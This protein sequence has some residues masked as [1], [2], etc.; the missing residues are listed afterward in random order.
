MF[1]WLLYP[2]HKTSEALSF[3]RVF[4]Y[5][6][7]R[8][9]FA[10]IT[11][12]LLAYYLGPKAIRFLKKIKFG[13]AISE[14]GP[15]SHQ[16][17]AGTPTMGG[18][19]II[20]SMS[21]SA[22]LWGNLSNLY[23]L[24]LLLGTLFLSAVGFLDDYQKSILKITGGMKAKVKFIFQ[25]FIALGVALII[26]YF[27]TTPEDNLKMATDLYLPFIKDPIFNMGIWAVPFWVIVITGS[28]NAVNLTDGLDG[29]A[30]GLSVIVLVTLGV[31]S[32]I[33]GLYKI[34]GYLLLP[35]FPE[36]NE[37]SVFLAALIGASI[38]FLWY[39][40]YPAEVFMGD[41]G[42]LAIGG[43]VGITAILIKREILLL[44]IGGIFVV[45]VISVILQVFSYKT[46]K[47]RIF[48]M[49]PLHHH[50]ELSGWHENKVVIRFWIVGI[51]LALLSLS[52]LKIV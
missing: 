16:A 39:N 24:L 12:L 4:G 46:R 1:Y 11:S 20:A 5:V 47:K 9:V 23:F 7:F 34:A 43:A 32:Y 8:M 26:Y 48:K 44:I 3:F 35:Y 14:D 13:E 38:G 52:S 28:S 41:T 15:K 36:A 29:L 45:E 2:L 6:T 50:Y 17:K 30:I 37:I 31:F 49:A 21:V 27:P 25:F 33:T 18:I 22:L 51:L 40:S 19:L 42:S 10:A